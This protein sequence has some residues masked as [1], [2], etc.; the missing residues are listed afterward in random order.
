MFGAGTGLLLPVNR[1]N[2]SARGSF[3]QAEAGRARQSREEEPISVEKQHLF[4]LS[5]HRTSHTQSLSIT[6]D[7]IDTINREKCTCACTPTHTHTLTHT[8]THTHKHTF[9]SE[10]P[11]TQM[12]RTDTSGQMP[13]L[14][15]CPRP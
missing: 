10:L 9:S 15:P 12:N 5:T 13:Y 11:F 8:H 1:F 3:T 7:V 14:H 2:M 6:T 4:P